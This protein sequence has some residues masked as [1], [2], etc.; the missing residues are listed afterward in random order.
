[1]KLTISEI[2]EI[3]TEMLKEVTDLCEKYK[4]DYSLAYGSVLG[5][6]RHAGPIPWDTDVDIIV[7]YPQIKHFI[8]VAEKELSSKF[9]LDYYGN[10]KYFPYLLLR[11]GLT[12]YSS[13]ILHIDI[14]KLVGGPIEKDK[15]EKIQNKFGYFKLIYKLLK[16]NSKYFYALT[17]KRKINTFILRLLL[18][19]IPGKW[20]I[21]RF[22][23][24]C[25]KYPYKKNG[26][27]INA[28]GDYGIKEVLNKNF[29][30]SEILVKYSGINVKI[31]EDFD[32]YLKHFYNNYMEL[33]AEDERKIKDYYVI[34]RI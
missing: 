9:Y 1:M 13:H 26:V 2:Q 14:Y 33:P 18:L 17:T 23:T 8:N 21:G 3:E 11:I 7:P 20:L 22:K 16:R 15:Q 12:G 6:V 19:P 5:T 29:Y 10:N 32:G 30:V 24:L 31:P 25:E 28:D 4:I 34:Q 27:V